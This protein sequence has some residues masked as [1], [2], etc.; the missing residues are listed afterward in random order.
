MEVLMQGV[1]SELVYKSLSQNIASTLS[2]LSCDFRIV[3]PVQ[4]FFY[5]AAAQCFDS[6]NWP[7]TCISSFGKKA[8]IYKQVVWNKKITSLS[9]WKSNVFIIV[10]RIEREIGHS[11]R[12]IGDFEVSLFLLT[13][14]SN[15]VSIKYLLS[16]YTFRGSHLLLVPE[17]LRL[18]RYLKWLGNCNFS[19]WSQIID[20]FNLEP[21]APPPNYLCLNLGWLIVSIDLCVIHISY[22]GQSFKY[23]YNP[24]YPQL[25]PLLQIIR[26]LHLHTMTGDKNGLC[27]ELY[28]LC[29]ISETFYGGYFLKY[30]NLLPP[31][32]PPV[33]RT[34]NQYNGE[35]Y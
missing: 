17:N 24:Y 21:F 23:W 33:L 32:P 26:K 25:E 19:F 1:E 20:P 7:E 11:N 18:C 5:H 6:E 22:C 10:K 13:N 29:Y 31:V 28:S 16:N 30:I 27:S 34:P 12:L 9:L 15:P 4:H 3:F 2:K 14:P 35:F 8:K